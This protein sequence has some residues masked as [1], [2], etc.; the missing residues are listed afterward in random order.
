M[1]INYSDVVLILCIM[2]KEVFMKF[3]K[4][5]SLI[6]AAGLT[7]PVCCG[8]PDIKKS[9]ADGSQEIVNLL[10][11]GFE[12]GTDDWSGR[13]AASVKT[14]SAESKSG[15]ASL[16]VSNRSSAWN[17][18][19]IT[20]GPDFSAGS[21]YD[22][23][24][25]VKFT[26]SGSDD[27]KLS[28]QYTDSSGT[29]KYAAL[30]EKPAAAG[31]WTELSNS[32]YTIP[33]G[34]SDLYLYVE[35]ADSTIDFYVDDVVVKGEKYKPP[36][37]IKRTRGDMDGDGVINSFDL[38]L[39]RQAAEE[40][41]PSSDTKFRGDIDGNGVIDDTDIGY[42]SDFILGNI[43][44]FPEIEYGEEYEK[45]YDFAS[46]S[47]LK[48]S[49]DIPDP[50][51]FVDGSTVQSPAEWRRRANEISCMYEY[52]MYGK[53]RDGS[54]DEVS[55]KI[56]G[57]TM[58]ITVKRKSTGKT[59]SFPAKITLPNKVRH[60][61]GAPVIVGMHTNIKE[62]IAASLGYAVI[63]LDG[64]F[65]NP[66]A[67]DND[68]HTGP[69]YTLYPYGNSWDEQTGVL[70]AWSWGC[71]KILDALYNGAGE[72]LN[73]NPDSSIVTG[74]S[75]WGKATAVCG[76]YDKRFKMVAPSCSGAGG[77]ALYRY[78]S[79]G[80]TYDFSS[81]GASSAY[82]YGA[83][84]H[85]GSLQSS[86][87]RGWFN[88]RFREFRDVNQIPMDQH[89]L[90]SLVAD[91]DRYLF[92]IGSC[93]NEDWVNAPAMWASYLGIK[94]VYDF[95]GISDNL[96]INIHTEGHA[97]IEEDVR[98]MVQYFDY[99]VYGIKPSMDLSKLQTSVF[100]L[101][102]NHDKYLDTFTDKWAY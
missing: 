40:S 98:Y 85:L 45:T 43:R 80:K 58:T 52:Y 49:S 13:G 71:S 99:H 61:G 28:L 60:E 78:K 22:A 87:E 38:I 101:P 25:W 83:N 12:K 65:T 67:A 10:E 18:A 56:S 79:Q 15:T 14:S 30:A 39:I 57:N 26:G 91:K 54:D 46:V 5:T 17:G 81:K 48:S 93:I 95:L 21:T 102:K 90:G 88:N 9:S 34:A 20:L 84:E 44:E 1:N 77:L 100:A 50:F 47:S 53:W 32:S 96:A 2:N 4:I 74:V 23:S 7:V 82:T 69:F 72:E 55:Y 76:A 42:V 41:S 66:V 27:F 73:I 33:D 29:V 86:D 36:V 3:L 75:R 8:A 6:L 37:K 64:V 94:R 70:M 62:N 24:A 59:A 68:S 97:V 11:C 16:Y 92:I 51:K 63:C 31:Q 19:V 89:M 35:T